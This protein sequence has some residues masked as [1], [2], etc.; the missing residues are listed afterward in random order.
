[1]L[2]RDPEGLLVVRGWHGG[3]DARVLPRVLASEA[4]SY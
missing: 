4:V 1:L 3:E 2:R